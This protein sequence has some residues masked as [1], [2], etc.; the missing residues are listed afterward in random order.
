MTKDL[1]KQGT[2]SSPPPSS[3]PPKA[4][5]IQRYSMTITNKYVYTCFF[6]LFTP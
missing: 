5:S 2:V 3:H 4:I 1:D 6:Y